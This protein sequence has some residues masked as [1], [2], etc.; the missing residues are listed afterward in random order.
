MIRGEVP[1][2]RAKRGRFRAWLRW[3]GR[4]LS[5]PGLITDEEMA[6]RFE[7]S[8]VAPLVGKVPASRSETDDNVAG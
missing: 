4:G 1:A 7:N 3:R 8:V 6:R 2:P 5:K